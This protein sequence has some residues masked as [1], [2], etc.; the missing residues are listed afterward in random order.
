M[1]AVLVVVLSIPRVVVAVELSR[2]LCS[3]VDVERGPVWVVRVA[4]ELAVE[5]VNERAVAEFDVIPFV[6]VVE[7]P[8]IVLALK[9]GVDVVAVT[10]GDVM[11]VKISE[12][13][14]NDIAVVVVAEEL[15]E[16]VVVSSGI[17][18]VVVP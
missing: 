1:E 3:V 12:E 7:E 15:A 17:F 16:E 8:N 2:M 11:D 6:V 13:D 18:V 5:V 10:V 9:L 14:V 4:D